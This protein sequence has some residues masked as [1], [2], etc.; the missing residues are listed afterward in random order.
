MS[1][2]RA[3]GTFRLTARDGRI[4]QSDVLDSTLSVDEIA[5]RMQEGAPKLKAEGF[6][7]K[8]ITLTGSVEAGRARLEPSVIDGASM[9]LTIRGDVRFADGGL[10]LNGLVAP[11]AG[12]PFG[13]AMV[14]VPVGIRGTITEPQVNVVPAAAVGMTLINLLT[15][16]FLLPFNLF[17]VSGSAP[18]GKP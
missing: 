3:L 7:Y 1:R 15:A 11:L 2:D 12:R 5:R 16:R 9:Y 18:Q 8:Q 17:D 4:I 10:D 13:A 14:V 6:D